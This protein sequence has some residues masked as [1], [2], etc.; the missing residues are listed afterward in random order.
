M[1]ENWI[2]W[3]ISETSKHPNTYLHNIDYTNQLKNKVVWIFAIKELDF[4]L[5]S[6]APLPIKIHTVGE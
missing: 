5:F 2:F 1:N 4:D 3:K 6:P